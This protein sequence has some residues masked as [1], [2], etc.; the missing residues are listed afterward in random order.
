MGQ[1]YLNK[2]FQRHILENFEG[3]NPD[4]VRLV[5]RMEFHEKQYIVESDGAIFRK[6]EHGDKGSRVVAPEYSFEFYYSS[7][8]NDD[9]FHFC[10][11]KILD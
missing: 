11:S 6:T 10:N 2:R 9:I 3:R 7:P 5:N 1:F 8:D 4:S